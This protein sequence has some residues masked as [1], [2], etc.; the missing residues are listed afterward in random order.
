MY[1][2]E[3]NDIAEGNRGE[4]SFQK[5]CL[6]EKGE[7]LSSLGCWL[8]LSESVV[9]KVAVVAIQRVKKGMVLLV[10]YG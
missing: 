10:F 4:S 8:R 7:G 9:E 2:K 3:S 6:E 1:H 5:V